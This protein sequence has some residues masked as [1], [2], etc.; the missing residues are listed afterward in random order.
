[1]VQTPSGKIIFTW[2][3]KANLRLEEE[4]RGHET[5]TIEDEIKA[6]DDERR[7]LARG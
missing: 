3:I 2:K 6:L 7:L 1:M 5:L 4:A